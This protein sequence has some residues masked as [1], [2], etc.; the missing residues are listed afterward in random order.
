MAVDLLHLRLAAIGRN[1]PQPVAAL[2][3]CFCGDERMGDGCRLSGADI[4]ALQRAGNEALG[5][6]DRQGGGHWARLARW[7]RT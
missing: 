7:L 2:A 4:G 3:R 1:A 5:L 6:F